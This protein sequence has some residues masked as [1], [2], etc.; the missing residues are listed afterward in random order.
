MMLQLSHQ[1][2]QKMLSGLLPLPRTLESGGS[3]DSS[4]AI[5]HFAEYNARPELWSS[6]TGN[7]S[8]ASGEL[9]LRVRQRRHGATE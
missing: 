1:D 7:R 5:I 9:G 8:G 6:A 3:T 2:Q 4:D